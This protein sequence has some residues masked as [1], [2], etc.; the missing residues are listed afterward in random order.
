M[1]YILEI[2]LARLTNGLDVRGRE[3]LMT[4]PGF[5]PGAIYYDGKDSSSHLE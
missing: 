1:G 3:K 4:A 5:L 2:E